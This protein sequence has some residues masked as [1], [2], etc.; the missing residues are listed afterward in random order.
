[1]KVIKNEGVSFCGDFRSGR[2]QDFT[3][4]RQFA[5]F[6]L[7]VPTSV[8]YRPK[9]KYMGGRDLQL[10][11]ATEVDGLPKRTPDVCGIEMKDA[12]PNALNTSFKKYQIKAAQ[13]YNQRKEN[14]KDNYEEW[15][16]PHD[17]RDWTKLP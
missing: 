16:P 12:G 4:L 1:M 17:W 9:F 2:L 13:F 14:G 10:L 15:K 8:R 11:M 6:S 5:M 7:M 3:S